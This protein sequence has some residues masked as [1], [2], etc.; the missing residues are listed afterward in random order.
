MNQDQRR[1]LAK[2]A[3]PF[4]ASRCGTQE[5]P[6][7]APWFGVP[8]QLWTLRATLSPDLVAGSTVEE[9]AVLAWLVAEHGAAKSE[10]TLAEWAAMPS[11]TKPQTFAELAEINRRMRAEWSKPELS[12]DANTWRGVDLTRARAVQLGAHGATD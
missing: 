4:I 6:N 12:D 11:A 2:Q 5:T 9:E 10:P 7:A 3:L 8:I 1:E